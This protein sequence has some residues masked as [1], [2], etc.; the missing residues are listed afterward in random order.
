M[1]AVSGVAMPWEFVAWAGCDVGICDASVS[2]GACG[3]L[4]PPGSVG[5]CDESG[6]VSWGLLPCHVGSSAR[7]PS[8][9]ISCCVMSCHV[10]SRH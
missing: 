1:W 6:V 5:I 9:I 7:A 10:L 4:V 2:L 3:G 8:E